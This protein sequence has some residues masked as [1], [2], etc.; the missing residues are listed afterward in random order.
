MK[1]RRGDRWRETHLLWF[2]HLQNIVTYWKQHMVPH[3]DITCLCFYVSVKNKKVWES[4][5]AERRLRTINCNFRSWT[6]SSH[7]IRT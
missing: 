6:G 1:T 2:K 3:E 5:R 4:V 7:R